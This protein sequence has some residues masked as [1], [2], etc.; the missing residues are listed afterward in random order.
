MQILYSLDSHVWLSACLGKFS[1]FA[2][3]PRFR[4]K[5]KMVPPPSGRRKRENDRGYS[6]QLRWS[7][8]KFPI[9]RS[10]F[11]FNYDVRNNVSQAVSVCWWRVK[12]TELEFPCSFSTYSTYIQ[13][14]VLICNQILDRSKQVYFLRATMKLIIERLSGGV[15]GSG[16]G[17]RSCSGGS[18]LPPVKGFNTFLY[19]RT[20]LPTAR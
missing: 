10:C 1:V 11:E 19:S 20:R 17:G 12:C 2:A 6:I 15:L 3:K 16:A 9:C 5:A 18:W 4:R 8:K 14:I 7:K 13:Y